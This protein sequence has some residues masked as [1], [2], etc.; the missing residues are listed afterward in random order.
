[1]NQIAIDGCTIAQV[2]QRITRTI[3]PI[4]GSKLFIS[5]CA[6]KEIIVSVR[7]SDFSLSIR[8][9]DEL[10]PNRPYWWWQIDGGDH[11]V[12][13]GKAD[14]QWQMKRTVE[15]LINRLWME[16]FTNGS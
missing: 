1:M 16:A 2:H 8:I 14:M 12:D 7:D 4:R 5:L 9:D 13:F 6:D 10:I 15:K 11:P 3:D